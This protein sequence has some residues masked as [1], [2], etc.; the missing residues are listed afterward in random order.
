MNKSL[1]NRINSRNRP[2][3]VLLVTL[4]LLVVLSIP[5]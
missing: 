1:N 4:V 5:G 3:I 2:G